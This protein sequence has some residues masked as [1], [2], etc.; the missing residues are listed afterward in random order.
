MHSRRIFLAAFA[1]QSQAL[2]GGALIP[3]ALCAAYDLR[4]RRTII[5]FQ[6]AEETFAAE[7]DHD[8][9]RLRRPYPAKAL[10][11]ITTLPKVQLRIDGE[12]LNAY[13]NRRPLKILSTL[14]QVPRLA[15]IR[16][17]YPNPAHP[18]LKAIWS[19]D[20]RIYFTNNDYRNVYLLPITM[21]EDSAKPTLLKR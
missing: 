18:D 12:A 6:S 15:A 7:F 3:D 19:I 16:I 17:G 5:Y 20:N 14:M 8:S 1:P 9:S 13:D 10:P 4:S 2:T 21:R 11:P